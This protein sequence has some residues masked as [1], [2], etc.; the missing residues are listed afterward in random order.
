MEHQE[1]LEMLKEEGVEFGDI[2]SEP[3]TTVV[4]QAMH[5]PRSAQGKFR[6]LTKQF[7]ELDEILGRV[8][9]ELNQTP[10]E[11]AKRSYRN[12]L[13]KMEGLYEVLPFLSIHPIERLSLLA[14]QT[15]NEFREGEWDDFYT[16]EQIEL[17]SN[18]LRTIR[19]LLLMTPPGCTDMSL[20]VVQEA[21]R[22]A[23]TVK[24]GAFLGKASMHHCTQDRFN[25]FPD[26]EKVSTKDESV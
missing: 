14:Q 6:H 16:K 11:A 18:I 24:A 9:V 13:R 19:A 25:Y 22:E 3:S 1:F 5:L 2:L 4:Y 12:A 7:R 15:L 20:N 8:A 26:V 23:D 17:S 10:Y 21:F